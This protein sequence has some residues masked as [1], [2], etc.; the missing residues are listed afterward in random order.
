MSFKISQIPSYQYKTLEN[1]RVSN[2]FCSVNNDVFTPSF[3]RVE[4]KQSWLQ[5]LFGSSYDTSVHTSTINIPDSATTEYAKTLAEGLKRVLEAD[6][7][8]QNLG[9]IMTPE[10]FKEM[11][12]TMKLP[13]YNGTFENIDTGI[14]VADLDFQTNFSNG[15]HNIFD[16]LEKVAEMSNQYFAD[17]RKKFVFAIADRDNLEGIQH[18][19]RI[20]G[21]NPEKFQHVKILPAVKLSYTHEAPQS[22][23]GFENSELLVYGINP[24]SEQLI[25]FVD[26][27]GERRK[28]MVLDFTKKVNQL[29]PE[30]SYN[31]QEFAEQNG[32]RYS[33]DYTASNL[34]WRVR[35]YAET[36]GD[37][38]IRGTELSP[39]KIIRE[40]NTILQELD[41][42]YRGS[43]V[44]STPRYGSSLL[45]ENSDVN[46]TIK[47][48]FE[49]F[50][51]HEDRITGE[52][53]S[54]AESLYKDIIDCLSTQ[55]TSKP[56]IALASPFYLSHHFEAQNPKSYANVVKFIDKLK[57]ESNGMLCAF[58]S[59]AP[60]Y[61]ADQYLDPEAVEKF[62]DYIRNKTGLYEVGGSFDK[63]WHG[64]KTN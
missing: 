6:V 60:A 3:G 10:E 22:N 62:N 16:I 36:K 29:Y 63:V 46:K 19:I 43:D 24:F 33:R 35:E 64:E 48:V 31:I 30:F 47:T 45:D 7:L 59:L 32:L 8:P 18:V 12:P 41:K 55:G 37:T 13:N 50:S 54:S 40:S 4:K 5:K 9:S 38:A 34:Y 53:V 23:I 28:D 21:E 2:G 44:K 56:V 39:E 61:K 1:K 15:K 14:Y 49:D 51:T 52:I 42:V 11:L 27:L 58:E 26:E 17:K 25:K 20:I 57:K